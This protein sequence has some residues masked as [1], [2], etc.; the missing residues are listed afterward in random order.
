[1]YFEPTKRGLKE[2]YL[3]QIFHRSAWS[4]LFLLLL[5]GTAMAEEKAF[6]IAVAADGQNDSSRISIVA[7]RTPFFLIFNKQGRLLEAI[8]NPYVNATDDAGPSAANFLAD[9]KVNA[10]IAG[11]F[12]RKMLAVLITEKIQPVERQGLVVDAVR[13][14]THAK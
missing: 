9:K 12:G 2:E 3:M 6:T 5:T 11:H 8:N 7:A 10:V 4:M 14:Q 1:M 13:E